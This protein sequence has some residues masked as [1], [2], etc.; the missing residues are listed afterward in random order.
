MFI[1]GYEGYYSV[2]REGDVISEKRIITYK[3]GKKKTINKRVLKPSNNGDG[4][5]SVFLSKNGVT[6][7]FYVH[8][9][10]AEMFIQNQDKKKCVNHKDGNKSNN[11]VDN[12]EW[13]SYSE[14][15][16]HSY[17]VLGKDTKGKKG[18]N[19][20]LTKENIIYIFASMKTKTL[21]QISID[22]GVS[23]TAIRSVINGI[24]YKDVLSTVTELTIKGEAL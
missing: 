9:I 3:S 18:A 14:N 6:K 4:Y 13:V 12:L 5:L 2:T 1:K 24:T 21:K 10:V 15:E 17:R 19:R 20:K 7:R 11:C 23:T 16:L 8:R 22:V